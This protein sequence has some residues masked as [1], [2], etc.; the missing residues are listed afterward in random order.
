[1]EKRLLPE[2][3]ERYRAAADSFV[4]RVKGDP[5][6]IAVIV[7]GSLAYDTVWEKS[8]ID[9]TL[10]IRDQTLQQNAYCLDEDGIII[11]VQ[12]FERSSFKRGMDR[13]LGGSMP[14]SYFAK[15]QMVYS[16]D[17]SLYDY[18]E[19][20]RRMGSQD[21]ARS[22]LWRS[23][24]LIDVYHKCQKWLTVRRDR[25]Y[26]QF[27]L[28]KAADL[29][30]GI[31]LCA[32]GEP[33]TREAVLSMLERSPAQMAPFYQNPLSG[34]LSEAELWSAIRE[35]EQVLD[36][37]L[38]AMSRPVLEFMSDQQLKTMTM[39]TRHFH[40]EGH[41]LINIL[42]Y[43]ADKGIIEKVSQTIRMTSKSKPAAEEIGFLYIP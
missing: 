35:M 12:L 32:Q 7:C 3:Q 14:Q 30:A 5:N 25:R 9:M 31:E 42:D 24:E 40:M 41:Y 43:M 20:M 38:E 4:D 8:D 37:H 39:L 10:I 27:F 17:E 11:N 23:C 15:G 18:F 1:M 21:I 22:L 33:P 6:I 26:T 2:L 36:R 28:L 16:S 29:I 13:L 19:D 34:Q